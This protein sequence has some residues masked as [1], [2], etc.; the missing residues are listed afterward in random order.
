[1]FT[2]INNNNTK[3]CT[4]DAIHVKKRQGHSRSSILQSSAGRQ[5]VAYRHIIWLAVRISEVLEDVIKP[6]KSP[7]IAVVD[8]PKCGLTPSPKGTPANMRMNHIF[9]ETRVIG[10]HF[11]R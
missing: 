11:C 1:M 10:L 4:S 9:P 7:K 6:P 2:V 5:G 3:N 8:N